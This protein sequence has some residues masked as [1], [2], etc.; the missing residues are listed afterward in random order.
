MKRWLSPRREVACADAQGRTARQPGCPAAGHA[1]AADA[2]P[3]GRAGSRLRGHGRE[4]APHVRARQGG[5]ARA[6]RAGRA[7]PDRPVGQRRG[8][9]HRPERLRH[10]PA[11]PGAR[12][13]RAAGDADRR[14]HPAQADRVHLPAAGPLAVGAA[15]GPVRPGP[16]ARHL[17]RGRA[18]QRPRR[19]ALLPPLAHPVGRAHG[20]AERP[21]PRVR[22]AG[23][24]RRERRAADRRRAGRLA[25]RHRARRPCGGAPGGAARRQ[26]RRRGG[27]GRPRDPAHADRRPRGLRGLGDRQRHRGGRARGAADAGPPS[28]G[29]PARAAGRGAEVSRSPEASAAGRLQ[30]LLALVPWVMAHPDSTVDEVCARFA[31]TREA[32]AADLELLFMSGVPPY[33]PGDLMEAWIEGERVH[34]GLADYFARAPRLTW[35]EAAGL[36]LA[37]RALASLRE[38]DEHGALERALAKLETVLPSDQLDRIQELASRVSVDLGGGEPERAHRAMLSRA[39][40]AN[41]R[42]VLEY[43]SGSRG[44]LSRRKVDPWLV[45]ATAGH[46][47]MVGHCHRAGGE[48]LFRLDRVVEVTPTEEQFERPASFDPASYSESPWGG[49]FTQGLECELDLGPQAAWVADWLPILSSRRRPDGRLRVK[50]ATHE[51]AWVVRLVLRL[52]PDAEPVSPPELR[53]AVAEAARR[54]LAVYAWPAP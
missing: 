40:A 27:P 22:G 42:V 11:G 30:R 7:W 12:R 39:A 43:Y 6:R 45:F 20:Q 21:L 51:L 33:G 31:M 23:L 34:I 36:Y 19:A 52:A 18:R 26:A 24:V 35:R 47:Y 49:A 15:G 2:R 8:L 13:A 32:L 5:A 14:G 17:V 1:S 25:D 10:A 54:V 9:F 38:L 37:G 4:P 28:P 48:R 3:G 50:L 29:G 44:D 16:P 53:H 41:R 46:W